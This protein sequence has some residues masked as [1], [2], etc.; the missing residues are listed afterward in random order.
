M[1]VDRIK[2]AAIVGG[3]L[4]W[5][6][7]AG[8]QG[9]LGDQEVR[10]MVPEGVTVELDIPYREGRPAWRLDLAMPAEKASEL[11]P[12]IV[13]VHG[14]GWKGGDKR[15]GIFLTG[16]LEYA[17]KGYVCITVNYRLLP[18]SPF[19]A[20]VEDVKTAVRWLRAHAGEYGID[21]DRIGAFGNSA[22]AHLV[23]M[24]GLVPREAALEGDGPYRE[25]SSLVQAVC[26]GATPTD[27]PNWAKGTERFESRG[28]LLYGDPESFEERAKQASPITYVNAD[29]PPFLLIHGTRDG[30]VDYA[31]QGKRFV[32]AAK[33]AGAKDV[34]L[35]TFEGAGHGVVMERQ[36]ET[37]PAIEEFFER[38]LKKKN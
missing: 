6:C 11:R 38:T 4:F 20:C 24:L 31:S 13:F 7:H 33:Q 29:M 28:G 25:Q 10:T 2:T 22:G 9:R 34:T 26:A 27:F 32:E 1:T 35:L 30:L 3:I 23:C 18:Q 36:S 12:A 19:P 17:S 15:R 16:A 14:G 21:P 5:G 8:A 37:F